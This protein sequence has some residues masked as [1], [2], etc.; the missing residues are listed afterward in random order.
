MLADEPTSSLDPK[1]SVEIME[2]IAGRTGERDI[3]V[4]INIHNVE[5]ARRFADRIIGMS[6]GEIV[7]DGAPAALADSHLLADLRRRRMAGVNLSDAATHDRR[8]DPRAAP[9]RLPAKLAGADRACLRWPLYVGL[10]DARIIDIS[11]ERF[12]AGLGNGSRF[13]S[14]MF[15]PNIARRQIAAAL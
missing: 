8:P 12:A 5:L 6:K 14:R 3:P 4:I 13:L 1:T 10:R 15:P 2:L 9:P 11:W 7:F